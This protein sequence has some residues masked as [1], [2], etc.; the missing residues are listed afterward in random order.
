MLRLLMQFFKVTRRREE[1]RT[2][3]E[4][5]EVAKGKEEASLGRRLITKPKLSLER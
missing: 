2:I 1:N 4:A 3:R 5:V